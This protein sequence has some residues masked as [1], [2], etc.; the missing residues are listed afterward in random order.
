MLLYAYRRQKSG[1]AKSW[2]RVGIPGYGLKQCNPD[3][4]QRPRDLIGRTDHIPIHAP[5]QPL[6]Y[7][8]QQYRAEDHQNKRSEYLYR[9]NG[10]EDERQAEQERNCREIGSGKPVQITLHAFMEWCAVRGQERH[11]ELPADL[12]DEE[13][14]DQ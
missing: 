1:E 12:A 8:E 13:C 6:G 9:S 5:E 7:G 10:E 4:Y 11:G 3:N 14:R 2:Y